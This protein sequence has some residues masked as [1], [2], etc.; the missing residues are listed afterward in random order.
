VGAKVSVFHPE[1]GANQFFDEW[2]NEGIKTY[3]Q[4]IPVRDK[5]CFFGFHILFWSIMGF[6][7]GERSAF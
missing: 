2:P 1:C 5:S 3:W 6:V 4:G 7:V